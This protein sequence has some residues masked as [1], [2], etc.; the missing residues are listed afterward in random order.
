MKA[1]KE[2]KS[3]VLVITILGIVF[4]GFE[5]FRE[6]DFYVYLHSAQ[7]IESVPNIY[8]IFH[9]EPAVF[10]YYGSPFFTLFLSVFNLFPFYWASFLFKLINLVLLIRIWHLLEK[11]FPKSIRNLQYYH[12]WLSL[13]FVGIALPLFQNFHNTQLTILLLYTMLEAIYQIRDRNQAG[14]GA[15]LV[16][17]GILI[18]L[19]PL[20]M[21]PYLLYRKHLMAVFLIPL[22]LLGYFLITAAFLSWD[23]NMDLWV[24]WLQQ[25]LPEVNGQ[26]FDMNNRKNHGVEAWLATLLVDGVKNSKSLDLKRNILNLN[27]QTAQYIILGFRLFLVSSF[28][29]FLQTKPF[30]QIQNKVHQL[31]ELSYLLLLIPLIF[32]QQRIYNFVFLFPAISYVLYMILLNKEGKKF[33]VYLFIFSLL[34]LNLELFLGTYRK[35]FWHY[36]TITYATLIIG[37][38][39]AYFKPNK[40]ES[41]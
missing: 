41:K 33:Y 5:F 20:V 38:V 19:S 9:G 11:Y 2:N 6:G 30:K 22:F 3:L 16:A 14:L 39:L 4:L 21:L 24:S 12:Y 36:K 37:L 7:I 28:L 23:F 29:Y 35:V 34:L 18:K 10:K 13:S 25:I 31:W 1:L 32:P 17:F 8:Q 27:P 40:A 26:S 15:A